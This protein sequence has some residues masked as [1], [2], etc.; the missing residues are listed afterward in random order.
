MPAIAKAKEE[1]QEHLGRL[2]GTL[3]GALR[4]IKTVKA[5]RAEERIADQVVASAATSAD[6]GIR[7]VR[8]EALAWTIAWTG[9]QL[10]IIV[11]LAAGA[12][13]VDQGL[14]EVS[15]LIA[16]LLYAFG[17]MGPITELT[18][19]VT[20]LQSGIAAAARIRDVDA[21]ELE[22]DERATTRAPARDGPVLALRGVTA[23][24]GPEA[25]PAVR[26]VTLDVPRRGHLA[27]VGPSGAGKTTLL[28]LIL[29]F[30]EPQAGRI[31]LDGRPYEALSHAE[32]RDRLAYVEQETPVVP[33]TIRENV[34]LGRPDATD[35][36]VA[37]VMRDLRLEHLEL[38]T[39]LSSTSVSGGERQ[40]IALARA[41]LRAPD[42]LLLDEATAQVDGLTESAIH[43]C[44]RA[45]AEIGAV[46]TVA[47]RLSTVVDAD[48]IV[49]LE[50]GRVRAQG[51]HEALLAT[52]DLY[53]SFVE[54]LRIDQRSDGRLVGSS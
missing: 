18:Q 37:A 52:D 6:Y 30:L 43:D 39:P 34:L 28:S 48:S 27:I 40:R 42:V 31:E 35:A 38:D 13:R 3:E 50:D 25:D 36:E 24:Y 4:A 29:R 9:V 5:N 22:P 16:F 47:H 12:W 17:L 33:G 14:L 23:A 21:L 19:N 1:A 49:V 44:I 45:R 15:S 7:A 11:I 8:K 26:E 46:V 2:G 20:A 32:V 54:A 41:I 53:R 10:A 51:T